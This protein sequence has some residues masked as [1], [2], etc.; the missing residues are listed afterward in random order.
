MTRDPRITRRDAEQLHSAS[1]DIERAAK[2]SP[3]RNFIVYHA[4]F[5]GLAG[6]IAAPPER[7]QPPAS[8]RSSRKGVKKSSDYLQRFITVGRLS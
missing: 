1:R 8:T 7:F 6:W 2:D 4:A 3:D 5:L